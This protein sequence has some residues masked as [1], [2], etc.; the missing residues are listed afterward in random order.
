MEANMDEIKS[1][2][3]AYASQFRRAVLHSV[4]ELPAGTRRIVPGPGPGGTG[5]G[6]LHRVA[7]RLP[8][9]IFPSSSVFSDSS[10]L[11]GGDRDGGRNRARYDASPPSDA[12]SSSSRGDI[13]WIRFGRCYC[14]RFQVL[15]RASRLLWLRLNP[16]ALR[17]VS[18]SYSVRSQCGPA[19]RKA[20]ATG[21]A[22]RQR[23]GEREVGGGGGTDAAENGGGGVDAEWIPS[24]CACAILLHLDLFLLPYPRHPLFVKIT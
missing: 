4:A 3:S 20:A 16:P 18:S 7:P 23:A 19:A 22:T 24:P 17:W 21:A 11:I 13:L 12:A 15:R 1:K 9:K 14:G 2:M 6:F 5:G 10:I 8:N